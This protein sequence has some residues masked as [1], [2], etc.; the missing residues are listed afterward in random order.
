MRDLSKDMEI[1]KAAT[2]GPMVVVAE[3]RPS[4]PMAVPSVQFYAVESKSV[5]E[6]YGSLAGKNKIVV[7]LITD[8][9][10]A[11]FFAEAHEGWPE[12]I[13]RCLA[14][15]A[16]VQRLRGIIEHSWQDLTLAGT[17][18]AYLEEARERLGAEVRG[19]T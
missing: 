3:V 17:D 14:A 11:I 12:T 1:C 2:P 13:R 19:G 6:R 15:D 10:D 9:A 7:D 18:S 16:E 5:I 8:H 4:G